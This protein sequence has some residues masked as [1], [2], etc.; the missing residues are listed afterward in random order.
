M[1]ST[2]EEYEITDDPTRIDLDAVCDFLGRSYWAKNRERCTILRS[3]TNA[4]SFGVYRDG[5][6]VGFA[7]VVTDGAVMYWLGDVW[8]AEAHRGR[9]LGKALIDAVVTD[10]RLA[11]LVG[12][13]STQDAHTLYERFGFFRE[14]ERF[15]VRLPAA[16]PTSAQ[17]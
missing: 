9:G 8:V 5:R 12:I 4:I 6:Q 1:L 7:R 14:R 16:T 10:P 15:M 13:L 11:G 17:A 2:F 3:M